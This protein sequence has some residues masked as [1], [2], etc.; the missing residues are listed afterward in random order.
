MSEGAA[1]TELAWDD[2]TETSSWVK[3]G[4]Y[5]G[6]SLEA[7]DKDDVSRLRTAPVGVGASGLAVAGQGCGSH[8]HHEQWGR[9]DD[10]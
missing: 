4:G 6:L 9:A 1:Y 2:Q 3:K 5:L 7:M 8:L 10:E